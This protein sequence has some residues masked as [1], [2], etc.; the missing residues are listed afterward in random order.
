[1]SGKLAARITDSTAHSQQIL[2]VGPTPFIVPV[3]S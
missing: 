2:R 3:R 1:M